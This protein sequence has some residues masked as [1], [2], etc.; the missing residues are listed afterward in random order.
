VLTSRKSH[1]AQFEQF[2]KK[3]KLFS[4]HLFFRV[5]STFHESFLDTQ[6]IKNMIY[7][8]LKNTKNKKIGQQ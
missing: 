2:V 1:E 7:I 4:S 5:L 3:K 8:I 6:K